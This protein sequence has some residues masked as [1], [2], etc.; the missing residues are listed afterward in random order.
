M[1][2]GAWFFF[3]GVFFLYLLCEF[4]IIIFY[5]NIVVKTQSKKYLGKVTICSS[6]TVCCELWFSLLSTRQLAGAFTV[7]SR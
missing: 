4:Q 6:P 7:S 5:K 2:A 1:L 3:I